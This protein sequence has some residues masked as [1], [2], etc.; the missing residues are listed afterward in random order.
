MNFIRLFLFLAFIVCPTSFVS[1]DV[2]TQFSV[3]IENFN[4]EFSNVK[5]VTSSKMK[6]DSNGSIPEAPA[7]LDE[8]KMYAPGTHFF[9]SFDYKSELTSNSEPLAIKKLNVGVTIGEGLGKGFQGYGPCSLA[10][11]K[12]KAYVWLSNVASDEAKKVVRSKSLPG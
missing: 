4:V 12:G 11:Q 3:V 10:D 5:I 2:P 7:N 1:A 8:T 6:Q 9:V